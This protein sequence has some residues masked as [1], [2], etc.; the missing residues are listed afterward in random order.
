MTA[1][2]HGASPGMGHVVEGRAP[3][4][5]D[6][7]TDA[8]RRGDFP[9]AWAIAAEAMGRR[10]PATRD[11]PQLPYHLR[12]VW[13]GRPFAG[14]E[15]LVRCYHGLGDTLMFSRFLPLLARHAAR[16]TV[17]MQPHLLP[18]FRGFPGIDRLVPFDVAR[19]L[20]PQDCDIEIME[21]S[22]ALRASPG[23]APM[24]AL[25][26][27]PAP[28]PPST[29]AL[30]WGAGDW[31]AGRSVPEAMM[32]SFCHGPALSLMP[33]PTA[34][35]VLNPEGCPLN[36]V[37]TAELV[38][39]SALVVTVD[40]M[41]AHLAGILGRPVWLLAKHDPDWRWPVESTGT[42]WYPTVCVWRQP[43]P[44][45]WASVIGQAAAALDRQP[46]FQPAEG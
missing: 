39:G 13:D 33:G 15:V 22:L 44:G 3:S 19:P 27:L 4:A 46:R 43:A 23:G 35:P 18:L 34:L 38:A 32:Q 21:L 7:W 2:P 16:V 20:P 37:R 28:L 12:W 8:M 42:P 26:I 36:M 14:R 30:C 6:P 41:I 45:D 29:V 1:L 25:D 17:E 5:R 31:D 10:D 11:N 40:T 24:P 9:T